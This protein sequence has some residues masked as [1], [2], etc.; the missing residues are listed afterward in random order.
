M[1]SCGWAEVSRS[2]PTV[3]Q[4]DSP[5]TWVSD[6]G[7]LADGRDA[8]LS[9]LLHGGNSDR[10]FPSME[11]QPVSHR[12]RDTGKKTPGEPGHTR[13]AHRT[14][15]RT[16]AHGSQRQTSQPSNHSTI[17][18]PVLPLTAW[19]SSPVLHLAVSL[20]SDWATLLPVPLGRASGPRACCSKKSN[21][22]RRQ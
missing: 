4:V 15:G 8:A 16:R 21:P 1:N 6:R 5:W 22:S 10:P 3:D 20:S 11:T 13:D 12:F 14:H 2:K 18:Q 9:P 17:T 7:Q 19:T